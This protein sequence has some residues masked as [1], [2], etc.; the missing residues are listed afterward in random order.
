VAGLYRL[1]ADRLRNWRPATAVFA[2]AAMPFF[3]NFRAA[4]R[5]QGPE[6]QVARDFAYDML[7]SVEPYGIVFTNGDNDTFPLWY[8]QEAEGFRQDVQV[9][10]LSLVATDWFIR[11]L[12]DNPVRKFDPKQAP[13]F[14]DLAPAQVPPPTHSLTDAEIAQVVPQLLPEDYTFR[15]G[16]IEQTFKAGTALYQANIMTLRLIQENLTRRPIY[17]SIT[18]GSGAWMGLSKYLTE[19]ALVLRLHPGVPK[20]SSRLDQG[21]FSTLVDVPRTDSLI[22]HVYRYGRLF[23]VD[24]LD[25]DPTNQNIAS[26][27]SIPFLSLGNAWAIRGDRARS[28]ENF[29]R[30]YHLSP[31][32]QLKQVTESLAG[33]TVPPAVLGDTA[34]R[35]RR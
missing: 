26:N 1:A 25:L 10:N 20:D 14:A 21:L 19:E 4:S 17:F 16:P 31:S 22:W 28:V 33:E 15:V 34:R 8:L 18:A 29:R 3:L 11:Q 23:D 2:I 27:L 12:R 35:P 13:H 5:A 9:V 7:Q 6:A 30:A 32:P 24:S